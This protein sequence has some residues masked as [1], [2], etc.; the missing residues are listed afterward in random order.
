MDEYEAKRLRT[1]F[2]L[3]LPALNER[4]QRLYLATEAQ[5]LGRTGV[6]EVSRIAEVSRETIY[7]GLRELEFPGAM[8]DADETIRKE[9][10]GRKKATDK[11]PGLLEALEKLVD[12]GSRGDPMS[13]LRWT[14][15]STR[16][17]AKAL[18]EQGFKVGRQLVSELLNELGFSLQGNVKVKEGKQSEDRDE[19]FQYLNRMV[20]QFQAEGQP[21]I[22][23]DT[24]KK[25]LVGEYKNAGKE[26]Q[27]AGKPEKV[28]VYDFV[29]PLGRANPYGVYDVTKN[30]GWVSVGNSYDT[31]AFAVETIRRWWN[32]VGRQI[33]PEAT[34]LLI[35]A[36]GGGSNGSK[37]RLWKLE[38]SKFAAETG[39][40]I[41]VTHLPPGT[42]KW[43]KI[44]HRLFSY[45]SMNWRGRP[46]TSHE[47]IV[48]LIGSTTTKTGLK[49]VA[50]RDESIYPKGI[51]V[52]DDEM[53]EIPIQRHSFRG[54]WNY[55]I[56]SKKQL[57]TV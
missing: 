49:V 10:A 33:Y 31:A 8:Q 11:Q 21:A 42:S 7:R 35:A 38:L 45:I 16:Q 6:T 18:T 3:M 13:P 15:K 44:E 20:V 40:E 9:G 56:S 14:C 53:L 12:S 48:Q 50:E 22:S 43:N 2:E 51:K 30:T 1:K 57:Q 37:V 47:V 39:L 4:Q 55:T 41:T 32:A 29:G 19:Q 24:K 23:V 25:E 5:C 52:G 36:D 46:L 27:R 26:Y 34:K 28:G 17:L 54:D